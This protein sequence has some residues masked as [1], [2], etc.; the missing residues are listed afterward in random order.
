[1]NG[2]QTVLPNLDSGMMQEHRIN[3]TLGQIN[4]LI[5]SGVNNYN[6]FFLQG[7]RRFRGGL[8]LVAA[9]TFSKNLMSQGVDFNNQFDFHNTHAPYLL[10]QRHRVSIAGAYQ[11]RLERSLQSSVWR[12]ILSSWTMSTV[13]QFASGRPY[14]AVLG[15]ACPTDD[16]L[17]E[18]CEE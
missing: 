3:P 1:C 8:G 5:S 17:N 6:S 11:P 4:A 12:K 9:Y 13:M 7:Q 10:D 2:P 18:P 16:D 15:A 14:A